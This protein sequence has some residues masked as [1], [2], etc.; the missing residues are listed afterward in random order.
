MAD[1]LEYFYIKTSRYTKL[2]EMI[3]SFS[4]CLAVAYCLSPRNS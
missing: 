1:K 3:H 2:S 4:H